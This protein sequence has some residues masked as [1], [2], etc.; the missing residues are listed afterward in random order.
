MSTVSARHVCPAH[1]QA[2]QGFRKAVCMN[3]NLNAAFNSKHKKQHA[4]AGHL[5]VPPRT[6]Q[7]PCDS[8]LCLRARHLADP[9]RAAA[10]RMIGT[11]GAATGMSSPSAFSASACALVD[12]AHAL[13]VL[14]VSA[15]SH[16]ASVA[17]ST[18]WSD[19]RNSNEYSFI[20]HILVYF[21][22]ESAGVV[23]WGERGGRG[24]TCVDDSI[25]EKPFHPPVGPK[26]GKSVPLESSTTTF[27]S[28]ACTMVSARRRFNG[29]N[30]R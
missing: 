28:V 15:S 3:Q 5:K 13:L 26:S 1:I 27:G 25:A 6:H 21:H 10:I 7:R 18:E 19:L 30:R 22:S 8:A 29:G 12:F 9:R 17:F 14:S 16:F 2:V 20:T 24:A 4:L 23:L 11:R